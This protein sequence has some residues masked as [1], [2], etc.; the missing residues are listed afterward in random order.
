MGAT[1]V[2]RRSIAVLA[3]GAI[4]SLGV[5]ASA[6][7][8]GRNK[9]QYRTF[10]F[11]V[12]E[13][14]HFDIYYYPSEEAGVDIAARMAERW[15]ARLERLLQH[16][17]RGRQPLMLYASH[18]TSTGRITRRLTSTATDPHLEHSVHS[19]RRR[20]GSREP[21]ARGGNRA[22]GTSRHRDLRRR[23]RVNRS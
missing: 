19:I 2:P 22:V 11:Q 8:F 15:N 23:N 13:T 3:V 12:L 16:R 17:L 1:H 4:S 20:L 21:A 7:Y 18:V 5:P 6:Q 10:D 9:V 14:E